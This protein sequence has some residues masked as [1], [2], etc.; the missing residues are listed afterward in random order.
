MSPRSEPLDSGIFSSNREEA[1]VALARLQR[2]GIQ[3]RR[4][5][6][7]ALTEFLHGKSAFRRL[8]AVHALGK[9]GTFDK[10]GVAALE[11]ALRDPNKIIRGLAVDAFANIRQP[12]APF[13]VR[14]LMRLVTRGGTSGRRRGIRALGRMGAAAKK[15]A[16]ILYLELSR[17]ESRLKAAALE[18]L[19]CIEGKSGRLQQQLPRLL[20]DG[21]GMVR[22]KAMG[23]LG[24]KPRLPRSL[25]PLLVA[26][27][28]DR[29]VMVRP[30]A[31]RAL[32]R[33]TCPNEAIPAIIAAL[34]DK[35]NAGLRYHAVA[36]LGCAR[37][38]SAAAVHALRGALGDK[39]AEV[40]RRAKMSLRKLT[41]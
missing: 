21:D 5:A 32:S 25:L 39:D 6:A 18:A 17:K 40:R 13:A 30:R 26:G 38:T 36:A 8:C 20:L 19:G 29:E 12:A 14:R 4:E 1:S 9:I 22:A 3:T 7:R 24:D 28:G 23:L 10:P 35:G 41:K 27:L 34:Q 2:R 15:A 16:P 31:A 33:L 11:L 37:P